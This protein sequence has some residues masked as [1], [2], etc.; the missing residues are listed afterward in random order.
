MLQSC[1]TLSP[2]EYSVVKMSGLGGCRH[3]TG[4][5]QQGR[6]CDRLFQLCSGKHKHQH[7]H[8]DAPPLPLV[9][10]S[11]LRPLQA[12]RPGVPVR[13]W[14]G[15]G[16]G[17]SRLPAEPPAAAGRPLRWVR[18]PCAAGS[19]S[20]WLQLANVQH[21]G[22]GPLDACPPLPFF[23]PPL[24]TS[25]TCPAYTCLLEEAEAAEQLAEMTRQGRY[26]RDIW[27]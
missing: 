9:V 12:G 20:C 4:A 25:V 27:S 13:R 6:G 16:K 8:P 5:H 22:S 18:P 10:P 26:V 3:S 14:R 19:C 24:L 11:L 17:C 1:T 2:S 21:K 15:D 7:A 23:L